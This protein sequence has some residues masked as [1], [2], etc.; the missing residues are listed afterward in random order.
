M[1]RFEISTCLA[2]IPTGG[3]NTKSCG[4]PAQS[5]EESMTGQAGLVYN[6]ESDSYDYSGNTDVDW[7]TQVPAK[8]K[9]GWVE[10]TCSRGHSWNTGT[11]PVIPSR[12][13]EGIG[14]YV[15]H[16]I[17]PGDFLQ[18][19]IRNDLAGAV[20]RADHESLEVIREIVLYFANEVPP[21]CQGSREALSAWAF[22]GGR[23]GHPA[24]T[25]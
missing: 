17:P 24:P 14:R 25:T 7:N 18:A 9:C 15:E 19:V 22:R 10:L 5:I 23:N 8:N 1:Y 3:G 4:Q 2:P 20:A 11:K 21:E 16:G 12:I 6:P 13:M